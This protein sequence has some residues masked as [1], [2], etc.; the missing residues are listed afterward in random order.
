MVSLFAGAGGFDWGLHLTSG[1]ETCLANE[2]KARPAETLAKNLGMRLVTSQADALSEP[3]RVVLQG[4]V[5]EVRFSGLCGLNPDVVIGGPPCQD[6]SVVK[7]RVRKG[8]EVKRGR[9]YSHF[10]RALGFLQPKVFVFENVPGLMSANSRAAY[11][12]ILEDVQNLHLRWQEIQEEAGVDNGT[13]CNA[14]MGFHILLGGIVDAA[15][16]G[17]PQRR[18]R[19]IIIGLREDIAGRLGLFAVQRIKTALEEEVKG[20]HRS[21]AKYPLTCIEAFE[22]KPLCDLEKEYKDVMT[23]YEGLWDDVRTPR[24]EAWKE[25]VWQRLSFKVMEDYLSINNIAEVNSREI[26]EAMIQHCEV[27]KRLGYLGVPSDSLATSDGSNAVQRES[28]GVVERL[29]RIP[30]DKNNQF[31]DGTDWQVEGRGLSL[32]YRRA[33]PIKPAPTVVAYGGGGTWGYHYDRTRGVLSNRERARL[34]TFTDDFL[35]TGGVAETRAQ[36]GEAVPPLLGTRIGE[37]LLEM[38]PSWSEGIGV[39]A[40]Q[41][42][43]VTEVVVDTRQ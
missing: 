19:L 42:K 30:P 22:G 13:S 7:G 4:D 21:F 25:E 3:G 38:V 20:V 16:L 31:V 18:R 26:D 36:I 15:K 33:S 6:F 2:L 32:I 28:A 17:V 34:Q 43:G 27:L 8:V 40:L 35:F 1:F 12:M 37:I 11:E 5:A 10:V 9:L 14:R 23:A 39:S 41:E 29:R 24:A